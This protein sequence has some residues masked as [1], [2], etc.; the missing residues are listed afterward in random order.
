[1]RQQRATRVELRLR[2]VEKILRFVR[3]DEYQE[4]LLD[5]LQS[6]Y[7][8]SK[9]EQ[10]QEERLY[11]E[12]YGEVEEMAQTVL[13]RMKAQV[14]R[15]ALQEGRRAHHQHAVD[16]ALP[17]AL[18]QQ[19]DIEHHE[20]RPL[21]PLDHV[22]RVAQLSFREPPREARDCV[23]EPVRVVGDE[24]PFGPRARDDQRA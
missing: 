9:A 3:A 14:R 23:L 5:T 18:E 15:E 11:A 21:D 13:E 24:E 17:Q 7:K 8:L 22:F 6:Y 12:R 20:R 1:M 16:P 10:A 4:L 19:G 2:L